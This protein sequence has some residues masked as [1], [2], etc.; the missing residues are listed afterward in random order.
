MIV[1]LMLKYEGP[2]ASIGRLLKLRHDSDV[3]EKALAAYVT[4]QEATAKEDKRYKVYDSESM[5]RE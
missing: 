3:Y 5:L 4:K 1:R 2:T